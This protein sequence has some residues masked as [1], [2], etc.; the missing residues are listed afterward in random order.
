MAVTALPISVAYFRS[1]SVQMLRS[2]QSPPFRDVTEGRPHA[3]ADVPKTK[4]R[5]LR[6]SC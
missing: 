3:T 2:E 6:C 4:D 1:N 5:C